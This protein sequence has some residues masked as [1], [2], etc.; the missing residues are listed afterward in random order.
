MALA[1]E[2]GGQKDSVATWMKQGDCRMAMTKKQLMNNFLNKTGYHN[3]IFPATSSSQLI[4]IEMELS[5]AQC[6]SVLAQQVT[7]HVPYLEKVRIRLGELM[8][9]EDQV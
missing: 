6:I 4:S 5:L 7:L 2:M 1:V 8:D 9:T 3:L